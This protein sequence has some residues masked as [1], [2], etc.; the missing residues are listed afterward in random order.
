M[1]MKA[2]RTLGFVVRNTHDFSDI[3]SLKVLYL[4]LIRSILEYGFAVWNPYQ[5]S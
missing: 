5:L 4:A 3:L 2:T 1:L